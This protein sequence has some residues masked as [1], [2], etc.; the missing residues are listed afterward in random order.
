MDSKKA[1]LGLLVGLG[2]AWTAGA[3]WAAPLPATGTYERTLPTQDLGY[4]E[5]FGTLS[6]S[7][8]FQP[9]VDRRIES[10]VSV[11]LS[12]SVADDEVCASSWQCLGDR[13]WG[14]EFASISV[15]DQ[16]WMEVLK[17]IGESFWRTHS[18]VHEVAVCQDGRTEGCRD[19]AQW[20]ES[21]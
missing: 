7:H 10:I 2:L 20:R 4:V 11:S 19:F 13:I 3:A 8:A 1:G 12:V 17:V 18:S 5:H 15:D 16:A 9:L 6:W 21:V 14:R